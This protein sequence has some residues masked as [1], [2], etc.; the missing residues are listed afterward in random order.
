MASYHIL[1][2][3]DDG[4][5][6]AEVAVVPRSLADLA[7]WWLRRRHPANRYRLEVQP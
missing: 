5:F 6:L 3:T 7:L 1:Q 2:F 4:R